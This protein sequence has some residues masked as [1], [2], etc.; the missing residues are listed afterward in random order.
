[1]I[2]VDSDEQRQYEQAIRQRSL[3]RTREKLEKLKA[4]VASG[5]IKDRDKIVKAAELISDN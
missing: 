4:R 5:R 3:D 1:M 2:I